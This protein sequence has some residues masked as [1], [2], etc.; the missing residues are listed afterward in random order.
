V[1][2]VLSVRKLVFYFAKL[3]PYFRQ[4]KFEVDSGYPAI[5]LHAPEIQPLDGAVALLVIFGGQNIQKMDR[6]FG[7][8]GL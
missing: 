6:N 7:N 3:F 4:Y 2:S 8:F 1:F 5:K